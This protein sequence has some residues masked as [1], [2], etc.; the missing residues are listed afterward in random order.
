M[1]RPLIAMAARGFDRMCLLQMQDAAFRYA[2]QSLQNNKSALAQNPSLW[3]IVDLR[4]GGD[5]RAHADVSPGHIAAY[6]RA[7]AFFSQLPQRDALFDVAALSNAHIDEQGSGLRLEWL[8]H[9]LVGLQRDAD[10]LAA[11]TPMFANEIAAQVRR[12]IGNRTGLPGLPSAMRDVVTR[13]ATA[14]DDDHDV[15]QH[16][17]LSFS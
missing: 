2:A 17:G 4:L 10:R 5:G 6:M 1:C 9:T 16:P 15:D 7:K 13:A 14:P 3:S 12:T 8:A 11:T